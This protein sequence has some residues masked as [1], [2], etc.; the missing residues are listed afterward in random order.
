MQ[1]ER[2]SNRRYRGAERVL[3]L[4]LLAAVVTREIR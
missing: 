3:G 4:L 1:S 2:R